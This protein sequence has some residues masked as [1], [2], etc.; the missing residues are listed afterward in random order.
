MTTRQAH[1][2]REAADASQPIDEI[3]VATISDHDAEAIWFEKTVE[4]TFAISVLRNSASACAP[5]SGPA[6]AALGDLM[7]KKDSRL[8]LIEFKVSKAAIGS[9]LKKYAHV[10]S[11]SK[12]VPRGHTTST[13]SNAEAAPSRRKPAPQPTRSSMG[14]SSMARSNCACFH[15]GKEATKQQGI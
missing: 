4:Y 15:T 9:E 10:N 6:E 5:L 2:L 12:K 3:D 13:T 1:I 11:N 8:R 7:M 14:S